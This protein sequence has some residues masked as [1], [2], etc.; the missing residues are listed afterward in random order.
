[1]KKTKAI[2]LA[3]IHENY[4]TDKG[5]GHNY[6]NAYDLLFAPYQH[7]KMNFM[8]VGVL[9][10]GSLELWNE[11]FT[12]ASIYGVDDFSQVHTNSDFGGIDVS[13][14]IVVD[15]L[16]KYDR[17]TFIEPVNARNTKAVG[18][19]IGSLKIEFD[20]II[21][22]GDHDPVS[23]LEVFDNFVPYL[24]ADGVYVIEDVCGMGQAQ[25][26]KKTIL[27]KYSPL[28]W[29]PDI[30]IMPFNIQQRQDDILVVIK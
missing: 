10:G 26:I 13:H 20:I 17:V 5:S 21:D 2:T 6:I 4:A 9:L 23:Q 3:D 24:S 8:E 12:E 19:K 11:Y 18:D 30:Q 29:V 22:D 27:E 28:G 1:M 25:H 15:K 16:K 14:D 7:K